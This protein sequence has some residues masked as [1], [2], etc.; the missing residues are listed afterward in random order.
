MD[1]SEGMEESESQASPPTLPQADMEAS[2]D[3]PSAEE[4]VL[5]DGVSTNALTMVC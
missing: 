2:R 1:V 4:P 3:H 5:L